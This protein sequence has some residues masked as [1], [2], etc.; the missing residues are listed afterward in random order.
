VVDRRDVGS[1]LEGPGSRR[2][3]AETD[4]PGRRLGLPQH[5]PGSLA[6]FGRRLVA[7]CIDWTMCQLIAY[8]AFGVTVG[9]GSGGSWTPLLVFGVENLLLLSTLGST[10]GQRLLGLQLVA[11]SGR[12]ATI[13]QVAMRTVLLCLAVPALV[14]DR[15]QRGLHDK[16]AKTV[17]VRR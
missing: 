6:R 12:P 14:W 5:G 7:V 9:Q 15:D 11:V 16:A 2:P 1:W 17:L 13:G 8:V 4:Y 10:F 3:D